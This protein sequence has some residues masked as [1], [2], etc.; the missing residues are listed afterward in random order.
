MHIVL[1]AVAL[2][3]LEYQKWWLCWEQHLTEDF[4]AERWGCWSSVNKKWNGLMVKYRQLC[5]WWV[6]PSGL[7]VKNLPAMQKMRERWVWS[8]GQEDSLQEGMVTHS[9]ILVWRI[10]W[11]EE[12]GRLQSIGSQRVGRDWSDWPC[13]Y[14]LLIVPQWFLPPG[15]SHLPSFY[16]EGTCSHI[17][18]LYSTLCH[19]AS[20]SFLF[21]CLSRSPDYLIFVIHM[22]VFSNEQRTW[23]QWS[24]NFFPF[25]SIST[26]LRSAH[27]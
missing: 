2:I 11:A 19:S 9:S 8:W 18:V 14:M 25:F 21:S 22:V 4:R 16:I 12:P 23:K 10:P 7:A 13:T 20:N 5:Y 15:T 26:E 27:F 3:S 17:M 24:S 6:F 1:I